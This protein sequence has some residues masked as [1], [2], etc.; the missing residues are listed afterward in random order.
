MRTNG[1]LLHLLSGNDGS[2]I[3]L[4]EFHPIWASAVY[5]SGYGKSGHSPIGGR[6]TSNT[7]LKPTLF[8]PRSWQAACPR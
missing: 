4:H 3:A 8:G 2:Q 7:L 6:M 5:R 1:R